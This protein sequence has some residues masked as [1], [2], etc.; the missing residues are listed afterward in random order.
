MHKDTLMNI[1]KDNV[2]PDMWAM[3]ERKWSA[4]L[5][6]KVLEA[7]K[8]EKK[9]EGETGIFLIQDLNEKSAEEFIDCV[10]IYFFNSAKQIYCIAVEEG[11]Y[12][13]ENNLKL[14]EDK[15]VPFKNVTPPAK[16]SK[17]QYRFSFA[18]KIGAIP[19][20]QGNQLKI[21][22]TKETGEWRFY[23]E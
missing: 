23:H 5:A 6:Q 21:I 10:K 13:T 2:E 19:D 12:Y 22:R 11:F 4:E 18:N 15:K 8:E 7:E 3:G 20:L 1:W 9:I 17:T 16:D 14:T